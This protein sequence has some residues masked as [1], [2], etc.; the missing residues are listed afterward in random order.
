[1]RTGSAV[2]IVLTVV[3]QPVAQAPLPRPV[4]VVDNGEFMDLFLKTTY[5]DLQQAMA[6]PPADRKGWAAIYQRAIQV[7]EMQN[8]S[9]LSRSSRSER[10][11]LGLA[12][13][14]EQA[15]CRRPRCGHT[16]RSEKRSDGGLRG[17]PQEVPRRVDRLQRMPSSLRARGADD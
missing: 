10:S 4:P 11:L 17:H 5:G 15:E 7:A 8:P 6:K 13:G 14:A 3:A 9:L 16:H 12:D 2:L 1:M